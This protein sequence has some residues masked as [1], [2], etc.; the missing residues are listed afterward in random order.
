[1]L[2]THDVANLFQSMRTAYG[3]QWKHGPEA[4]SVWV[5]ALKRHNPNDVRKA[6]NA[7]LGH[8]VDFPPS[9]P[10]FMHIVRE[11]TPLLPSPN[12]DDWALA[13]RVH[14][15]CRLESKTN[16]KG[17]PHSVTLPESIARRAPGESSEHYEKR[18]RDAVTI[19][20]YPQIRR[21]FRR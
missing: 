14:A 18:I 20:L 2:T 15:Y 6:A 17:N 10:Q 8:Y 12:H 13:D 4:M 7:V 1:M 11:S 19:A 5:D 21:Q 16:P 9:L 3:N